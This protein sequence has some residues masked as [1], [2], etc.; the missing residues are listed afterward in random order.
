MLTDDISA[1]LYSHIYLFDEDTTCEEIIIL[2][3]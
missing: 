1:D 2:M 3:L